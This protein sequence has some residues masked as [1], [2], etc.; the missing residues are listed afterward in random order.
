MTASRSGRALV[1]AYSVRVLRGF[2]LSGVVLTFAGCTGGPI[3]PDDPAGSKVPQASADRTQT[4]IETDGQAPVRV[5]LD[6]TASAAGA[7]PIVQY[8]WLLDG[9]TVA[10]GPTADVALQA[11]VYEFEL[12]VR[13]ADGR[14]DRD[15]VVVTVAGPRRET[16]DLVIG[17][18]GGEGRIQP[19]L[20]TSSHANGAT[21]IVR[22]FAESGFR[23]VRWSGDLN[24]TQASATIL[25]DRDRFITAEFEAVE[26]G[27]L[28][29]FFA[30]WA[31]GESRTVSQGNDGPL[32]HQGLFAWDFPMPIGTPVLAAG[33]GRVVQVEESNPRNDPENPDQSTRSNF[34]TLDH[35][36][37]LISTYGHLDQHGVV[38][39]PG[40]S[41]A[42]GQLIAYSGDT[43]LSTGPHLHYEVINIYRESV[44]TGLLEAAR[45]DGV[46]EQGD[47]IVSRNEFSPESA[48][49]YVQSKLP[50]DV[51]AANRVE[52]LDES[53]PAFFYE[54]GT[55]YAVRG[56]VLDDAHV[57][58]M[59]MVDP[60]TEETVLCEP[61]EVDDEGRFDLVFRIPDDLV[62]SFFMGMIAGESGAEGVLDRQV[63]VTPPQRQGPPQAV[64]DPPAQ[65]VLRFNDRR[66]LA[67]RAVGGDAGGARAYHWVQVAGPAALIDDTVSSR[68]AF[69]VEPGVGQERITFQL[70]VFD[71][72]QYSLPDQVDFFMIDSF[73]VAGI[74][75]ADFVCESEQDCM[76]RRQAEV[77][78]GHGT[79]SG[80]V[81][82]LNVEPGDDAIFKII[83]PRGA[84]VRAQLLPE[85][86]EYAGSS[87]LRFA[88][89]TD[90]L[91][92]LPGA[93]VGLYEHNGDGVARVEFQAAP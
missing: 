71:G 78:F 47:L 24:T 12:V 28:P 13:D 30:P 40:Q 48:A 51:Y 55:D 10:E 61:H 56:R 3:L 58:C 79:I 80:F 2:L 53:L 54:T 8:E 19:A 90:G 14:T 1:A 31:P 52:L 49:G 20:G 34:V 77:S 4:T 62:G 41:V 81:K 23:F 45:P 74:G 25:M 87:F 86:T 39:A 36:D 72:R 22:A 65:P 33:A 44:P 7:A 17:I 66:T 37:G 29:R 70:V 69:T 83:D 60:Q 27:V 59:A 76:D 68:T 21:V 75:V 92:P 82:L 57:V 42:R 5:T 88:W 91:E 67:G 16:F 35:G 11:G 93:W 63:V 46:A 9:E 26:A 85:F 18:S 6:G 89:T 38:V 32:S 64:I 50:P 73:H 84:V 15:A 43:G